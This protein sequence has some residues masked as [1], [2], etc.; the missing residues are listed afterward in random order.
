MTTDRRILV[1]NA[2]LSGVER[3][4]GRSKI[5]NLNYIDNDILCLEKLVTA[6]LFSDVIFG[7]DDYKDKYRSERLKNFDF[8]NFSEIDQATYASFAGDAAAFARS[9]TVSF[10]GSKPAGD[11]IRFFEALR[12]DPQLRWDVFV[13]SEYLTLSL[14]VQDP[15]YTRYEN[16][17]DSV[18]RNEETDSKLVAVETDH[19]PALSVGSR[20]DIQNIKDFVRAISSDNPQFAGVDGKSVLGRMLFGF[21]WAAER[22]HF[23][24]AVAY[25]QGA[26]AY[27][28][29]LRDAF[30]ESCCRIDYPSEVTG[31]LE[32]LKLRSQ[33]TLTSIL[34]PTGRAKFAI[35]LP[36]FTS[37]LISRSD[38]PLQCIDLALTLRS[39]RDFRDC[40]TIFHNLYHLSNSDKVRELNGI[41]KY[42][43]QS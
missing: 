37:Y 21:G 10:E 11:V 25:L 16:S 43:G 15:K 17:I 30:C 4:T 29:P 5:K 8:V 36:F 32:R 22:S 3:I 1:D 20:P 13:S 42:V 27:L 40:R 6:I 28:A 31:L 2:T 41:L 9:F 24:N 18:V 14:L 39:H 12:I 38:N 23:Y 7:I 33:E 35:R 34:D 19:D 26:D